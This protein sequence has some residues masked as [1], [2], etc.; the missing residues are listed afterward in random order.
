MSAAEQIYLAIVVIAFG[1]FMG[2]LGA[3][4]SWSEKKV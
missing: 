3:V 2:V 4:A 1:L